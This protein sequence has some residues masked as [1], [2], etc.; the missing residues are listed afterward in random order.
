MKLSD[1]RTELFTQI[2]ICDFGIRFV[3][4]DDEKYEFHGSPEDSRHLFTITVNLLKDGRLM[5]ITSVNNTLSFDQIEE[6]QRVSKI[7]RSEI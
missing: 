7:L 3:S 4:F 1:I 6:I 2:T 5:I